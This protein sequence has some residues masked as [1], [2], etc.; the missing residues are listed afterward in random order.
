MGL[1]T[2]RQHVDM[3]RAYYRSISVILSRDDK[4]S[5]RVS[6]AEPLLANEGGLS[7]S[8]RLEEHHRVRNRLAITS[9]LAADFCQWEVALLT[10]G[11]ANTKGQNQQN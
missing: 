2:R 8:L 10:T 1:T 11:Q 3:M 4:L 5:V 7:S 9:H 6:R